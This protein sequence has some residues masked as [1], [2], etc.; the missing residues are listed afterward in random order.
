MLSYAVHADPSLAL[1]L[2]RARALVDRGRAAET[3]DTLLGL[4][5]VA[6]EVGEVWEVLTLAALQTGDL[7]TARHGS[8]MLLRV[9]RI[10]CA[11][12]RCST[13]TPRLPWHRPTTPV[14][15]PPRCG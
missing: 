1:P 8:Q 10:C 13:S 11:A 3:L 12:R 2:D 6:P 9:A 4:S 5:R 7:E 14:P 15:R